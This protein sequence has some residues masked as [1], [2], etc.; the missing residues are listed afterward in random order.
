MDETQF[1]DLA[2]AMYADE[3]CRICGHTLTLEDIKA[4]AIWAGYSAD[5]KSRSAH[6]H[7]WNNAMEIWRE[8][9]PEPPDSQNAPG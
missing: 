4:G 9:H 3:P 5:G 6:K 1:I 8:M 2:L 7:C